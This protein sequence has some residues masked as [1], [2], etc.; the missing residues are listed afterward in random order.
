MQARGASGFRSGLQ[1]IRVIGRPRKIED[2]VTFSSQQQ[3]AGGVVGYPERK[4]LLRQPVW[5]KAAC[6]AGSAIIIDPASGAQNK[7][8]LQ[9]PACS[10]FLNCCIARALP[11]TSL[12]LSLSFSPSDIEIDWVVS[13]QNIFTRRVIFSFLFSFLPFSLPL[14]ISVPFFSI[15][16]AVCRYETRGSKTNQCKYQ[17]GRTTRFIFMDFQ[18]KT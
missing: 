1:H 14:L 3:R 17:T 9:R 18:G 2:R 13:S 7:N 16:L 10:L 15:H 4:R 6:L 12:S 11:P 8:T 5:L